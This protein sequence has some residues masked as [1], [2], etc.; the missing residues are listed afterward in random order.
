MA[1][2]IKKTYDRGNDVAQSLKDL[3]LANTE[4]W[5][6]K[7]KG[8]EAAKT[9]AKTEEQKAKVAPET[10]QNELEFKAELDEA[11]KRIRTYE[12]NMFKAHA[13]LWERCASAM[14]NRILARKDYESTICN[15]PTELLRAIK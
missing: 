8:S 13:L 9:E 4:A 11:M 3:K 2:H 6:P 1:N 12:N 15:D 5:K 10:R 7:L 14:Q